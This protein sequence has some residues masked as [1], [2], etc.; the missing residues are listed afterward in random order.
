L[1]NKLKLI[2]NTIAT[3]IVL[4]SKNINTTQFLNIQ[5]CIKFNINEITNL[6]VS[7]ILISSNWAR[8]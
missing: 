2:V 3:Q 6:Y 7:L 5:V 8:I 1:Q 4:E